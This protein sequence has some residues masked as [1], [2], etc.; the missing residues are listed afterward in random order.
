MRLIIEIDLD[1]DAF[2]EGPGLD[3]RARAEV[4][5]MLRFVAD[6]PLTHVDDSHYLLDSNGNQCGVARLEQAQDAP[7]IVNDDTEMPG[8]KLVGL[9][10]VWR[11]FYYDWRSPSGPME[12]AWIRGDRVA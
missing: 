2:G 11:G 4:A 12:G 8:A 9:R 5:R 1:N 6:R 10:R 3:A 7:D